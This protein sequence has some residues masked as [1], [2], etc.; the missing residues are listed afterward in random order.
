MDRAHFVST[1]ILDG[2]SITLDIGDPLQA[3]GKQKW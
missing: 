1:N 3:S 2:Q